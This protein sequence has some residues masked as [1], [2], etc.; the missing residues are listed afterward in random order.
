MLSQSPASSRPQLPSDQIPRRGGLGHPDLV[1]SSLVA[2][3]RQGEAHKL[4]D[5][6]DPSIRQYNI[7]PNTKLSFT[8]KLSNMEQQLINEKGQPRATITDPEMGVEGQS[9]TGKSSSPLSLICDAT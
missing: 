4:R 7:N 6:P 3:F 1:K 2:W 5:S 9:A 8:N